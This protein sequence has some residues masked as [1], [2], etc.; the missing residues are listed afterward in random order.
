M[1]QYY[2]N[3]PITCAAKVDQGPMASHSYFYFLLYTVDV[4]SSDTDY[5]RVY[6]RMCN[7]LTGYA[8][9]KNMLRLQDGAVVLRDRAPAAVRHCIHASRFR[10]LPCPWHALC[11]GPPQSPLQCNRRPSNL[12]ASHC[13]VGPTVACCGTAGRNHTTASQSGLDLHS[14]RADMHCRGDLYSV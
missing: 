7:S 5:E 2:G 6:C 13:I 4:E 1:I 10:D 14:T 11:M 3:R 9:D 8:R 12:V